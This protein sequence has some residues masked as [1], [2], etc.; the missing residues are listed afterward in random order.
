MI[1]AGRKSK[2]CFTAPRIASGSACS[3]PNVSRFIDVG[4]AVPIAY[5]TWSWTRSASPAAT[6]FFEGRGD[7]VDHE[8]RELVLRRASERDVVTVGGEQHRIVRLGAEAGPLATDQVHDDQVEALRREL[9][10]PRGLEVVGLSGE[11]DQERSP[12]PLPDLGEDVRRRLE[13]QLRRAGVLLELRPGDLL[14][15]EVRDRGRHDD[16]VRAVDGCEHGVA[17]LLRG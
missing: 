5:A 11:P 7:A 4:C 6:T 8:P 15:T 9:R 12:L 14:G 10:S 17:H 1:A 2:T 3:V 16:R 13:D